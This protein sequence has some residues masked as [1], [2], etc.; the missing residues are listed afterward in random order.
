MTKMKEEDASKALVLGKVD[1]L[2]KSIFFEC[3]D[4]LVEED[5]LYYGVYNR[6]KEYRG[7][8]TQDRQDHG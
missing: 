4:A 6:R 5:H 2:E 1:E 3:F 8:G 7:D